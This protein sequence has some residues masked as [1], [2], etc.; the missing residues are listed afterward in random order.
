MQGM[1]S[2]YPQTAGK[3]NLFIHNCEG[4]YIHTIS[5]YHTYIPINPNRLALGAGIKD[6]RLDCTV[7]GGVR[8][9]TAL[10]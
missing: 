5:Q 6:M 1:S 3:R 7:G 2:N 10:S 9:S 4:E 8:Y